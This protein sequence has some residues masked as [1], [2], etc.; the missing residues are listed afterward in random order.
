MTSAVKKLPDSKVELTVSLEK[1]E[2]L[3]FAKRTEEQLARNVKL[4]GFRPGKAP[5]DWV[6][7]KLGEDKVREEALK[8]AIQLSLKEALAKENLDVI[9]QL[10][11]EMKENSPEKLVYQ[12]T[13]LVFPELI[14]GKY[15]GLGIKRNTAS[16]TDQE[17]KGVLDNIQKS[18]TVFEETKRPA[19]IGDR[20]EVD[21]TVKHRGAVIEGGRSEN[22][23]LVIGDGSF[24][25][26]FEEQLIGMKPGGTKNFSL[27]VPDDHYQKTIAGKDLDFEVVMKKVEDRTV[28]ELN[29]KFAK[30]LGNFSS[31]KELEASVKQGLTMEKEIKERDRVRLAIL[32]KIAATTK[33]EIPSALVENRLDAMIQDLDGELHQKGMELGLYLAQIKKTQ[34]ELRRDWRMRAESQAKSGLIARAIAKAENLKVGEEEINEEL[35]IVLQ[36]Y[37]MSGQEGGGPEALQNI[38]LEKLKDKVRDTL[39]NEKVFEFLEKHN[40]IA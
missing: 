36:Q 13:F 17:I 7:K 25:P 28:P 40:V 29:D 23:P 24:I 34:D 37:V 16:T 39:L 6:R 11:L 10:G 9:D 3:S 4:E 1:G 5:K 31:L 32:E 20:V 33:V 15:K 38:N 19:Q 21:F 2:L 14:L 30:S 27:K 8:T 18:R 26:G 12:A 22:H 35:R